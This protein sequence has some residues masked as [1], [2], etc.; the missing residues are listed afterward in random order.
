MTEVNIWYLLS[1]L[2]YETDSLTESHLTES[3]TLAGRLAI[4]IHLGSGSMG[5]SHDAQLLHR[6]WGGT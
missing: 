4:G 5:I 3:A 6:Y 1:T 2:I